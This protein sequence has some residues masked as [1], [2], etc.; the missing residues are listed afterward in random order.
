MTPN[1]RRLILRGL[2]QIE[3]DDTAVSQAVLRTLLDGPDAKSLDDR[4]RGFITECFYGILRWRLRLD[5]TIGHFAKKGVPSDPELANLLRLGVYQLLFLDR[6][7]SHAAIHT[8]VNLTKR[9]RGAS[10]GRFVNAIL[11]SVDRERWQPDDLAALWGHPKWMVARMKREEKGDMSRVE[12]RLEANMSAAPTMLRLHPSTSIDAISGSL[13]SSH[14]P[15]HVVLPHSG[16]EILAGIRA[17]K[18]L[19]QDE[20]SARVVQYLDPQP[21]D[22]ILELCAGRGVKTTQLADAVGPSGLV[23]SVDVSASRLVENQRLLK[24]WAPGVPV[25]S[26]AADATELLP[27]DPELRFDRI[28]IDAPCSGLGVIR[29]RPETLWRRQEEDIQT[30]A[31]IQRKLVANVS[32]WLKPGGHCVYAVCTTTAEETTDIVGH[33]SVASFNTSVE[34]GSADGFYAARLA[35]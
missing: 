10:V 34:K 13:P 23:V 24:R 25:Y 6:V 33:C 15:H 22:R 35:L 17:G 26:L 29:R 20:S 7:P 2:G 14:V 12:Q 16:G 4:D 3:R 5:T 31:S 28:L 1:P 11:R 27:L 9:T 32:S 21:G 8:T 18:W 19:P 30:L